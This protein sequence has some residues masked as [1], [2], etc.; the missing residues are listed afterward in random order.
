MA[1][2]RVS[3][4]LAELGLPSE[5]PP[6]RPVLRGSSGTLLSVGVPVER[7]RTD[8]AGAWFTATEVSLLGPVPGVGGVQ[9]FP[10]L[11][12]ATARVARLLGEVARTCLERTE[13]ADADLAELQERG[14]RAPLG[15]VWQIKREVAGYGTLIGRALVVLAECEG[16]MADRLPQIERVA[17][18]IESELERVRGLI[19]GVQ[20]ASSD[21]VLLR[22]AQE[23]NRIAEMANELAR[24]SNRIASLANI[25]N[26]RML[27][28]TYLAFLLALIAAV[29]LI[30]NTGATILGMPSAAWVPG[31]WVDVSLFVLAAVP[32]Y[33]VFRQR[34]VWRMLHELRDFER[35]AVEGVRDLPE[36]VPTEPPG[37]PRSR[38]R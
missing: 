36:N 34:W 32:I 11:P 14:S 21:L 38:S 7:G 19:Q 2:T 31:I 10:G 28:M 18:S 33:V 25:S 4:A 15:Q 22:N 16:P 24:I 9:E 13:D 12:E 1:L 17:H 30:P 20:T 29:V 37:M 26:V 6:R 3:D 5:V 27:G 23:S 35:T 8:W